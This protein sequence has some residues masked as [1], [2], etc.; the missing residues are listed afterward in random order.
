MG[1]LLLFLYINYI[2]QA[3]SNTHTYLYEYDIRI[4]RQLNNVTE[5]ENVL[6][7]E[8]ASVMQLVCYNKLSIHFGKDKT[9]TAQKIKFSIKGFFCKCVKVRSFMPIW[10][11]LLKKSLIEN[12]IFC[13]VQMHSFQ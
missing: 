7:K 11:H 13:A 10:S 5:I 2:S 1:P 9:N 3:L 4:F 12:F 6:N 8:F